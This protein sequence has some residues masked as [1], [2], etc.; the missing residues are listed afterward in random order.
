MYTQRK[1]T[2]PIHA[3]LETRSEWRAKM[4]TDSDPIFSFELL[5]PETQPE[6]IFIRSDA[7]ELRQDFLSVRTPEEAL[8]FFRKYGPWQVKER[9]A[10][11]ADPFKWSQMERMREFF[12][13]ALT[14]RS[15]ENTPRDSKTDDIRKLFEN[16]YLWQNLPLELPFQEPFVAFVRCNDIQ[17][18]LRAGIFLSR[19]GGVKWKRCAKTDC[20]NL[21]QC[22][23][24]REQL[25]CNPDCANVQSSRNYHDRKRKTRETVMA[26]RKRGAS[27]AAA[28]NLTKKE[29]K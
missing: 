8:A 9:Y 20:N 11:T 26:R 7:F 18:A 25:Y 23:S 4:N 27:T 2:L 6:W 17:Q 12:E 28:A 29:G 19:L 5:K 13:D 16:L 14:K 22:N 10:N 1:Y 21:F 3:T 15:V 24:N